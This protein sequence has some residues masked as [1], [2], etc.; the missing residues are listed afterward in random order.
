[1]KLLQWLAE[2]TIL[3]WKRPFYSRNLFLVCSR[4][5]D[6]WYGDNNFDRRTNGEFWLLEK[7]MPRANIVFDVGANSGDY[8]AEILKINP[9][10]SVH[11]FEPDPEPYAKLKEFPL[12][13]NNIALGEKRGIKTLYRASK[14]AHNSF[15]PL[16]SG[17]TPI[18]VNVTTL[19]AYCEKRGIHHIDFLKIDV[20]GYEFFVLK[21]A[22]KL[23]KRQGIDYIQFEF[24]GATIES[25]VFL[26][27]FIEFFNTYGYDLYRIR[28][29][30]V[31]KVEH[32]PD[33]ERFTLTNYLAI[34]RGIQVPV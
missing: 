4:Y 24:S 9:M 29:Q 2:K 5:L 7:L 34:K 16:E 25:R 22:E 11:A 17:R 8:S 19:D 31:Q 12:V 14:S 13:A 15:Y 32:A 18:A 30:D 28:A 21:G 1:M 26:K 10:V 33:K 6:L 27:D 20:E 3:N 23:L